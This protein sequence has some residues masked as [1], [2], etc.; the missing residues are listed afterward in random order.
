MESFNNV[1]YHILG[2]RIRE[3]RINLNLN[4]EE[5]AS[6]I[7]KLGRTSISNI[8]KGKQQPPLHVVYSICDALNIDIHNILPTYSEVQN[9]INIE[10]DKLNTFLKNSDIDELTIDTIK[11]LLQNKSK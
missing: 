6:K 11:E 1:L 5:L 3:T 7:N 9:E 2:K 10:S 8:E 4:Q